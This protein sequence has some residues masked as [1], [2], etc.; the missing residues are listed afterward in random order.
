MRAARVTAPD[1]VMLNV[2]A[3]SVATL[4]LSAV[5]RRYAVPS[6]CYLSP[7]CPLV[8]SGHIMRCMWLLR[9]FYKCCVRRYP[10]LLL[11]CTWATKRLPAFGVG[12]SLEMPFG[13]EHRLLSW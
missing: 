2:Q 10:E 7:R 8:T 12:G 13:L 3:L 11:T 6:C 1:S 5:I 9:S 4:P